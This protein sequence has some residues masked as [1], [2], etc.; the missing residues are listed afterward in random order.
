M[1]LAMFSLDEYEKDVT[2]LFFYSSCYANGEE[3]ARDCLDMFWPSHEQN[4]PVA[5]SYS[6]YSYS[7]LKKTCQPEV[8][9]WMYYVL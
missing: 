2:L 6:V 3:Y 7:S 5:A 8:S 1:F 9:S 4:S